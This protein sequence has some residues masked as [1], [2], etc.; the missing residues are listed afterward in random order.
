M[1]YTVISSLIL[2]KVASQDINS[3]SSWEL[4]VYLR[5]M[6]TAD[7]ATTIRINSQTIASNPTFCETTCIYHSHCNGIS[8]FLHTIQ[9]GGYTRQPL[10]TYCR[11]Q[12][13]FAICCA[14][15]HSRMQKP[16]RQSLVESDEQLGS[17]RECVHSK[18]AT[19]PF[20]SP[21]C[22]FMQLLPSLSKHL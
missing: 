21:H 14:Y 6:R 13:L 8:T 9:M 5:F 2:K 20:H 3:E 15:I 12:H 17:T 10:F 7:L 11:P 22:L 19:L 4:M 18:P 1:I 16:A